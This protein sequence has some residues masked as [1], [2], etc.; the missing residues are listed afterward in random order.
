[1][2]FL[3]SCQ[4]DAIEIQEQVN[5]TI[6]PSKVL[7]SFVPYKSDNLDMEV[8]D[9]LGTA[10]LRI[11]VLIYDADG[12]L[13]SKNEGLLDDYNSDY[14]FNIL[15]DPKEEYKLLAFSSSI[16]GSLENITAESYK[17]HGIDNLNTL[18]VTQTTT[19]SWYSNYSVLG[20]LD[21]DLDSHMDGMR[22]DLRPATALVNLYCRSIHALHNLTSDSIYG[23]YSAKATDYSGNSYSWEIALAPG[24]R[25]NE[26]IINNL[27]PLLLNLGMNSDNGVNIYYGNLVGNKLIIPKGQDTGAIDGEQYPLYISGGSLYGDSFKEEDIIVSVDRVNRTLTVE[28]MWGTFSNKNGWGFYELFEKGVKFTSHAVGM[29]EYDKYCIVFHNND[30]VNYRNNEFTYATSLEDIHNNGETIAPSNNPK[31]DNIYSVHNLLPGTFE[32]FARTYIGNESADYG[33]QSVTIE[34][35]RQYVFILDCA[36]L[37]LDIYAGQLKSAILTSDVY[38]KQS[39][40]KA[41]MLPYYHNRPK[42]LNLTRLEF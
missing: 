12:E 23:K 16:M 31:S 22:L 25:Q 35:G 18:E 19:D 32:V 7:E 15:L 29:L 28:N 42:K 41:R 8:D 5:I 10:K 33:M 37:E 20:I 36:D 21:A 40:D 13:Y 17:F 3:V 24:E 27:S 34:S 2:F 4:N 11:T 14:S 39:P 38:D 26:V 30:V 6:C 1:M 9:E